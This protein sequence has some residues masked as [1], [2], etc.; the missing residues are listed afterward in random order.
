M[1]VGNKRDMKAKE[2]IFVIM[3]GFE[4]G[5]VAIEANLGLVAFGESTT[6]LTADVIFKVEQY[7]QTGFYGLIRLREFKDTV[8]ELK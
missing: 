4:G 1:S 8:I 5:R 7:F 6:D 2:L 3:E